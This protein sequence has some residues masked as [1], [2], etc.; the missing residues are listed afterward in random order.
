V[1]DE[2]EEADEAAR[3]RRTSSSPCCEGARCAA[4]VLLVKRPEPVPE[5]PWVCSWDLE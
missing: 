1:L 2:L 3:E 4:E 5:G